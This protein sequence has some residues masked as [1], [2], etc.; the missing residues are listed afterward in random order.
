MAARAK[1][2]KQIRGFVLVWTLITL[3]MGAC[4]FAAIY[5]AYGTLNT[6]G[7]SRS[8]LALPATNPA[9]AR[10]VI[11]SS[12]TPLPTRAPTVTPDR[13]QEARAVA[14]AATEAPPPS[15]TP[16]LL[17]V[18][19]DRFEA[20]IQVQVSYDMMNVWLDVAANQMK[21]RW[22][23]Q[24]VRWED[25]EPQQGQYDWGALDTYLPAASERGLKVLI[26]VV[27]APTGRANRA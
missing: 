24:Q 6:S 2:R 22:V 1:V 14:Q 8:N 5:V 25:I 27:T 10:A 7:L 21:L 19:D 4:T 23:K 13:T 11:V 20:G 9:S 16:T 15:P 17:P 3:L 18:D 26:S 12:N